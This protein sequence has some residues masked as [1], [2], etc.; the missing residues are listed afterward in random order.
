MNNFER[1]CIL[2]SELITWVF[3][4]Q[5]ELKNLLNKEAL[6][7]NMNFN[8]EE[9]ILRET[10]QIAEAR[11]EIQKSLDFTDNINLFNFQ[12]EYIIKKLQSIWSNINQNLIK[13][14]FYDEKEKITS[15]KFLVWMHNKEYINTLDRS[16]I[17]KNCQAIYKDT[18]LYNNFWR[19]T[20]YKDNTTN[21][22]FYKE[23]W[24][25]IKTFNQ[26]EEEIDH[27]NN[28]IRYIYWVHDLPSSEILLSQDRE[29]KVYI[30]GNWI[31]Y[32]L[33][34]VSEPR[35]IE[36][37]SYDENNKW[38]L[39]IMYRWERDRQIHTLKIT[40]EGDSGKEIAYV[41]YIEKSN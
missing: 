29:D 6:R 18:N 37:L 28:T 25:H 4:H 9:N 21:I 40:K 16:Y 11:S 20:L 39:K 23:S 8:H 34:W 12:L 17:N 7:E 30:I 10:K 35:R 15:N 33:K 1:P 36:K 31:T 32:P 22:L 27:E 5:H 41:N 19:S 14:L 13:A 2:P 38:I 24:W 26:Y 3:N